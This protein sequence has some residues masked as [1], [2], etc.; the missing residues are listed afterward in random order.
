MVKIPKFE[1]EL[2]K[3]QTLQAEDISL[4]TTYGR[5]YAAHTNHHSREL[6]LYRF[7]RDAVER[8][9][10][11][12]PVLDTL[13]KRLFFPLSKTASVFFRVF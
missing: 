4:I 6:V 8:Q 12:Q 7:F 2:D 11:V 1:V 3:K 10:C 5:L 13:S 9:A